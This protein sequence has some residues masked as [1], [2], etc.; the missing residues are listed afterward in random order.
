MLMDLVATLGDA[1][2]PADVGEDRLLTVGQ[3]AAVTAEPPVTH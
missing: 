2:G 1:A 3:G